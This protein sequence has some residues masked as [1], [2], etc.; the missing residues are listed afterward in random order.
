MANLCS[1]SRQ[2]AYVACEH[3]LFLRHFWDLHVMV[4]GRVNITLVNISL[5]IQAALARQIWR[6]SIW[7]R[8]PSQ[9]GQHPESDIPIAD[10]VHLVEAGLVLWL[11]CISICQRWISY[12]LSSIWAR[13]LLQ[14]STSRAPHTLAACRCDYGARKRIRVRHSDRRH[15]SPRGGSAGAHS[16]GAATG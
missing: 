16:T 6:T 5:V 2:A 4:Y 12:A 9:P 10:G 15:R 3:A 13:V 7:L 14:C 1:Y 11:M 8:I